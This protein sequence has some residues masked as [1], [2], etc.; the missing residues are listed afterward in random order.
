MP[1]HYKIIGINMGLSLII[2]KQ[3]HNQHEIHI[4]ISVRGSEEKQGGRQMMAVD[5]SGRPLPEK[6]ITCVGN[7]HAR[8]W[9]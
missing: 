4:L 7:I 8:T 5:N 6:Q 3:P 9:I 2:L 1:S